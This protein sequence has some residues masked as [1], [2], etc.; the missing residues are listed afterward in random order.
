MAST[1]GVGVAAAEWRKTWEPLVMQATAS[2]AVATT[3]GRGWRALCPWGSARSRSWGKKEDADGKGPGL[4]EE[5]E[6]AR[7]GWQRSG[8]GARRRRRRGRAMLRETM[9]RVLLVGRAGK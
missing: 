8:R 4:G 9:L 7:E 2:S 5:T 6:R 1:S 3:V